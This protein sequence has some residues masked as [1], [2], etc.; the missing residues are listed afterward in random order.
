MRDW[1]VA[2]SPSFY[3]VPSRLGPSLGCQGGDGPQLLRVRDSK[4]DDSAVITGIISLGQAI[5]GPAVSQETFGEVI[6]A[7]TTVMR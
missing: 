3:P 7:W 6:R 5:T 1:S 4:G 2:V